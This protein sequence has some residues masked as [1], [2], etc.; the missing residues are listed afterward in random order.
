MSVIYE[1]NL[2][3][4]ADIAGEFALWLPGHMAEMLALPGFIAADAALELADQ[5]DTAQWSVRYHLSDQDALSA[6]L[7]NHAQRMREDGFQ[8]FG[9]RFRAH[10]RILTPVEIAR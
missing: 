4:D 6:Y 8:R 3:V 7:Q 1:V 5:S 9:T 2:S 10:R